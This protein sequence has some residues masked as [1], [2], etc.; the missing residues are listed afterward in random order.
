MKGQFTKEV[1]DGDSFAEDGPGDPGVT[2]AGCTRMG[3][4]VAYQIRGLTEPNE[5]GSACRGTTWGCWRLRWAGM[6]V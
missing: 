1:E 6:C 3:E 4:W 2:F 5:D